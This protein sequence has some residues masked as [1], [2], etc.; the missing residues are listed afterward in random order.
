MKGPIILKDLLI[1]NK[2][3]SYL[4]LTAG[5]V[6]ISPLADAQIIYT[7][8]NPDSVLTGTESMQ[9]DIDKDGT[10]DFKVKLQS[11]NKPDLKIFSNSFIGLNNNQVLSFK[12]MG[13][14]SYIYEPNLQNFWDDINNGTN[15]VWKSG[16]KL[17]RTGTS[18]GIPFT[19]GLWKDAHDKYLGFRFKI[20][21]NY[22]YGWARLDVDS[23]GKSVTLKDYAYNGVAGE[24][25]K[26]GKTKVSL[27]EANPLKN[28]SVF[29]NGGMISIK[30]TDEQKLTGR[31]RLTDMNG[32]EVYNCDVKNENNINLNIQLLAS[33]IYIVNIVNEH[34]ILNKK[35]VVR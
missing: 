33:G 12:E 13:M 28:I 22:H 27:Q 10:F 31:I 19:H 34:G 35:V 23:S 16:G 20:T 18:N 4:A 32:R 30:A 8:V 21:G 24:S 3:K 1:G 5:F 9:L 25:I 26:A 14:S 29:S 7:D 17:L 6:A 15:N 2:L 11:Y